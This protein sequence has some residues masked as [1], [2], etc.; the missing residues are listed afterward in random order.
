MK[1]RLY[2][3]DPGGVSN[4]VLESAQDS[5]DELDLTD[6]EKDLIIEGRMESIYDK[7][8]PWVEWGEYVT[9]EIDLDKDEAKVV[10][11]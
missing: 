6:H 3:K 8:K 7:L 5:L 1:I 11:L 9:I 4:A 2:L 10:R